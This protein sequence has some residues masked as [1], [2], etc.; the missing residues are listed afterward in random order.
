M[1]AMHPDE[2][3]SIKNI[4]SYKDYCEFIDNLYSSTNHLYPAEDY[5]P[6]LEWGEIKYQIENEQ[7]F[8]FSG[9]IETMHD[10]IICYEMTLISL[11]REFQ[12]LVCRSPKAELL[13]VLSFQTSIIN[14]VNLDMAELRKTEIQPGDKTVPSQYFWQKTNE[15]LKK[16]KIT[17][18]FDKTFIEAMAIEV[19]SF[20]ESHLLGRRFT[21][22]ILDGNLFHYLFAQYKSQYYLIL[23]RSYLMILQDEW[24][25]VFNKSQIEIS[26]TKNLQQCL[27]TEITNFIQSRVSQK[28]LLPLISAHDVQH[29]KVHD[30]IFSAG[31]I[32]NDKLLAFYNLAPSYKRKNITSELKKVLPKINKAYALLNSEPLLVADHVKRTINQVSNMR[33]SKIQSVIFIIL[34]LLN[35]APATIRVN[36]KTSA[37]A[38]TLTQLVSLIDSLTDAEQLAD[39][40]D[41]MHES[42]ST[43]IITGDIIDIL[44]AFMESKGAIIYYT[45]SSTLLHLNPHGGANWRHRQLRVFW[46]DY[47]P[48][49]KHPDPRCLQIT[50]RTNSLNI[51]HDKTY[52]SNPLMHAYVGQLEIFLHSPLHIQDNESSKAMELIMLCIADYWTKHDFI[53]KHRF[54][55]EYTGMW[56]HCFPLKSIGGKTLR[57]L[58]AIQH[59]I[60]SNKYSWKVDFSITEDKQ[61]S[62]IRIVVDT[63]KFTQQMLDTSSN[64]IE[65]ALMEDLLKKCN[66][67]VED[68]G[69][70]KILR[71]LVKLKKREP[72]HKFHY[73]DKPA[74]FPENSPPIQKLDFQDRRVDKR[75]SE[76]ARDINLQPGMYSTEEAKGKLNELRQA[77][78]KEINNLAERFDYEK[79]VPFCISSMEALVHDSTIK[80]TDIYLSAERDVDFDRENEYINAEQGFL[81]NH[82]AY[83]YLIEKFIQLNPSGADIIT[84]KELKYITY[85][86]SKLLNIYTASDM[87]HYTEQP[88]IVHISENFAVFVDNE[89]S[90]KNKQRLFLE[91]SAQSKLSTDKASEDYVVSYDLEQHIEELD[92]RF[93]SDQGFTFLNLLGVL[94]LLRQWPNYADGEEQTYYRTSLNQ[95]EK[96]CIDNI[97]GAQIAEIRA[98]L[99]FLELDKRSILKIKGDAQKAKDLP[100]WESNKRLHRYNLRPLI[101]IKDY[102]LW[103][104]YAAYCSK[105]IWQNSLLDGRLPTEINSPELASYLENHRR[106]REKLLEKKALEIVLRFTPFADNVNHTR[107]T[108]PEHLGDYDVLA[109]IPEQNILLNI[110]CKD[111]ASPL[112]IKDMKNLKEKIFGIGRKKGSISKVETRASYLKANIDKFKAILQWPIKDN[113]TILSIHVSRV[114]YWLT[115]GIDEETGVKFERIGLLNKLIKDMLAR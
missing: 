42:R 110:E 22:H 54:F 84:D 56:I 82:R 33:D 80:K 34:P 112:V 69:I 39:F 63:D 55:I 105:S 72:R 4:L 108:H 61:E 38:I 103:G 57:D 3:E 67:I 16:M 43:T 40:I 23:P 83:R 11:D 19:G 78:V 27:T 49:L 74:A 104:P 1:V 48:G 65:I 88:L 70:D 90:A 35:S 37:I 95:L 64:D 8:F 17:D 73:I 79:S 10:S 106:K 114:N 115:T 98:I 89:S 85:M 28:C 45:N 102:Y 107:K 44:A 9:S 77:L 76:I 18:L 86:I 21:E 59:S 53:R 99:N 75:I 5:V 15:F 100:V 94:E 26:K 58:D 60:E 46:Q 87:I 68:N 24:G 71:K 111:I 81:E 47:P 93:Q 91:K 6:D 92:R 25:G 41:F 97:K 36:K 2:F 30:I 32:S 31:I 50:R 13:Q 62:Y 29:S 109:Y 66:D 113:A 14:A 96:V 12:E 51:I 20:S 101:K 52:P 7:Y